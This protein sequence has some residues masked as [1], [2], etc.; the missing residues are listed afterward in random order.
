MFEKILGIKRVRLL[1][2]SVIAGLCITAVMEEYS[3]RVMADITSN[4]VRLHVVANSDSESDQ[5]LKLKVR[6]A[7]TDYLKPHLED[8]TNAHKTQEII[9]SRTEEIERVAEETIKKYGYTYSVTA[10]FGEYPFPT[11][12]YENTRFPRGNY[13]ALKVVIGEGG[14][15]NWWCVLFPQLCFD[16][17][18]A[19][20]LSEESD[21]KLKNVLT[22]DE[23]NLVTADNIDFKFKIVELFS[24]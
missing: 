14:G 11:K 3:Q 17:C 22:Y 15:Q 21:A 20:V 18:T 8:V 9:K 13:Q 24:D 7:I 19:G 12:Y 6:D 2:L 16:P 23:Y 10:N 1:I 5:N 4:V